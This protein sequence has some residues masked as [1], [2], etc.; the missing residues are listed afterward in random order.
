MH[1]LLCCLFYLFLVGTKRSEAPDPNLPF[2]LYLDQN[3]LV[4]IKWGFDELRENI[5]ILLVVNTTG[6]VGLGFSPNGGMQ[7]SDIIMGGVRSDGSYFKDYY[8]TGNSMPLEDTHQSYTLLD[9]TEIDG[10]TK[11]RFK[12]SIISCDTQDFSI[13]AQSIKV[14][15]AYGTTDSISYHQGLRGTKDV[16]L[17]NFRT[18]STLNNHKYLSATMD[19]VPVAALETYYHCRIMKLPAL[20]AKHHIYLIK[21]LIEHPDIVH[22]QLLYRCPPFVTEPYNGDCSKSEIG[23]ACFHI[24]AAWAVGGEDFEFPENMGIP[25]GGETTD[26]FYRLEIHYSNVKTGTIDSSGLRLYY[27]PLSS[28]VQQHDIYDVGILATGLIPGFTLPYKIPPNVERFHTFGLCNTSQMFELLDTQPDLNVFAVALHTHYTGIEIEVVHVRN[29]KMI[30]YINV[31][32]NYN[33]ELQQ[34]V[35]LGSIKTIKK[36][37]EILVEC[38]Y[39]TVNRT[40]VTKQGLGS[41]DEMCLAFLFYYPAINISACLSHPNTNHPLISESNWMFEG[42]PTLTQEDISKYET[43]LMTVPQFQK[44]LDVNFNVSFNEDGKIRTMKEITPVTCNPPPNASSRPD[45]S[46]ILNTAGM[47]LLLLWTVII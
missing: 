38:V 19:K 9:A 18:R 14:I 33:F 42:N 27:R 30:D 15:Y 47:I 1:S 8:A 28:D 45:T 11:L 24:V 5:T 7:G 6:W 17:L 2:M 32:R 35:N 13:T 36:G 12:R 37:D 40:K 3:E 10:Q 41:Y 22:H 44:S 31:D 23:G 25:V 34:A 29:G 46:C 43:L 16:N 4:C 26:V 39:S 20:N 21:P